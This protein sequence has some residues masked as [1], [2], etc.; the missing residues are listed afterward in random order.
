MLAEGLLLPLPTADQLA[1]ADDDFEPEPIAG[2]PLS[3]MILEDRR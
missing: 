3:E 1:A 2:K